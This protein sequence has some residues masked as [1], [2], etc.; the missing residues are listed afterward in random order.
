M[1]NE[2]AVKIICDKFA[3]V[4]NWFYDSNSISNV[5]EFYNRLEKT[6][7]TYCPTINSDAAIAANIISFITTKIADKQKT[8]QEINGLVLDLGKYNVLR[9]V[10]SLFFVDHLI[11]SKAPIVINMEQLKEVFFYVSVK[12]STNDNVET[13]TTHALSVLSKAFKSLLPSELNKVE[14]YFKKEKFNLPTKI[15]LTKAF[16]SFNTGN[17]AKEATAKDAP[18][19]KSKTTIKK[20][21]NTSNDKNKDLEDPAKKH[22]C[23][24]DGPKPTEQNQVKTISTESPQTLSRGTDN[25]DDIKT[26][27]VTKAISV[28]IK[29]YECMPETRPDPATIISNNDLMVSLD[30]WFKQSNEVRDSIRL[31]FGKYIEYTVFSVMF[32]DV[33][34]YLEEQKKHTEPQALAKRIDALEGNVNKM[35]TILEQLA[36][37]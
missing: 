5:V 17:V 21:T 4:I 15:L 24:I 8:G 16:A 12:Q 33:Q 2:A 34:N 22:N 25:G 31:A 13:F 30:I 9:F 18:V 3:N 37:K 23:K 29:H 6:F 10:Q 14:D 11:N 36:N 28:L 35:L 19:V 26:D 1:T 27:A 32:Q 20:K 7:H